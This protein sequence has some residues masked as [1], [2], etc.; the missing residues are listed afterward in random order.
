MGDALLVIIPCAVAPLVM[1]VALR[2]QRR[3]GSEAAGWVAAVPTTIPIA[4]LAVGF[5]SGSQAA[6]S[7]TLTAA[8]HVPAQILFAV[9][10]AALMRRSGV[11]IGFVAGAFVFLATSVVI[12]FVPV[13]IAIAAAVAALVI[14][15]RLLA[16]PIEPAVAQAARSNPNAVLACTAAVVVVAA[17]IGVVR[18]AGPLVG[19]VVAA[20]PTLSST[21]TVAIVRSNGRLAGVGVL[22]GLVRGLPFYFVYLVTVSV[23]A[24]PAGIV[25]ATV[26]GLA[27]SAATGWI[28]WTTR[29]D[30]VGP[31]VE[32]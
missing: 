26:C 12:A 18:L 31:I 20:F 22:A 24:V 1:Y 16:S 14:G 32:I 11:A 28:L 5:Q 13:P 10:F 6:A 19:G 17:V 8:A 27:V 9:T 23:L 29:R 3:L 7:L 15:P 21:I 2:A 30:R 4:V 25:V